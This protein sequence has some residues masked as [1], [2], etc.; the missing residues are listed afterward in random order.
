MTLLNKTNTLV[1]VPA[2]NEQESIVSVI[3]EIKATGFSFV[4]I[5]DGSTDETRNRAIAAG[6]R[7]ISLPFNAG[8]GGALKCGFR[9]AHEHGFLAI[10]Q[11]DADGQHQSEFIE[12]LVEEANCG[13]SHIV[14]GSRFCGNSSMKDLQIFKKFCI[15][16]LAVIMS[17]HAGTKI[18]DPTSGFR[19]VRSPLIGE[20]SASFPAYY[21]GDTFEAVCVA[22]KSGYFVTELPV[23]MRDRQ[24]GVPSSPLGTSVAL[25]AKTLVVVCFGLHF[26]INKH[27]KES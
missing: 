22:A 14:L 20:F 6:A 18:S 12:K 13:K 16:T 15:N 5:D 24:A 10:V 27:L 21:L 25:V 8:V 19:L 4:V 7:T 3:E 1:I 26:R 11:C 2:Y 17:T 9:F 23:Q